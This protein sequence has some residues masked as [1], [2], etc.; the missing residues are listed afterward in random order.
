M[1]TQ[2]SDGSP[3]KNIDHDPFS[4]RSEDMYQA[5]RESKVPWY[6][7][8]ATEKP[9]M[10]PVIGLIKGNQNFQEIGDPDSDE[11]TKLNEDISIPDEP[12]LPT[13]SHAFGHSDEEEKIVTESNKKHSNKSISMLSKTERSSDEISVYGEEREDNMKKMLAELIHKTSTNNSRRFSEITT[14]SSDVSDQAISK[15]DK[16]DQILF[17]AYGWDSDSKIYKTIKKFWDALKKRVKNNKTKI[18]VVGEIID[19]ERKYASWLEWLIRWKNELKTNNIIKEKE[20][21]HLFGGV[22]ENIKIISDKFLEDIV[23]VYSEWE[24]TSTIG[25]IFVGIA[26]FFKIYVDYCNNNENAGKTLTELVKKNKKFKEYMLKQEKEAGDRF[27][28]FLITPIQRI[29]RYEMLVCSALKYTNKDYPDYAKLKKAKEM[30]HEVCMSN[31]KSM[32]DFIG[33]KRKLE[34][35]ELFG[36]DINLLLPQRNFIQEFSGMYMVSVNSNLKK[37]CRLILFSDCIM[38]LIDMKNIN[39]IVYFGNTVFDEH[40]FIYAKSDLKYYKNLIKIV[41]STKWF[42]LGADSRAIRDQVIKTCSEFIF[43]QKSKIKKKKSLRKQQDMFQNSIDIEIVWAEKQGEKLV[44]VIEATDSI[45]QNMSNENGIKNGSVLFRVFKRYNKVEDF[46]ITMCSEFSGKY[47]PPIP[48]KSVMSSDKTE[49]T[50]RRQINFELFFQTVM[51]HRPYMSHKSTIEFFKLNYVYGS[52]NKTNEVK[53]Y[54]L[55]LNQEKEFKSLKIGY[56]SSWKH[57]LNELNLEWDVRDIESFRICFVSEKYGEK[58]L[59]LYE[60]PLQVIENH[61][62]S[63]ESL[64]KKFIGKRVTKKPRKNIIEYFKEKNYMLYVRRVMFGP[65]DFSLNF[66]IPIKEL[67]LRY[68]QV[69]FDIKVQNINLPS[70]DEYLDFCGLRTFITCGNRKSWNNAILPYSELKSIIPSKVYAKKK[71]QVWENDILDSWQHYSETIL[72]QP[73]GVK[74]FIIKATTQKYYGWNLFWVEKYKKEHSW[75]ESNMWLIVKHNK[76]IIASE[77]LKN[78]LRTYDIVKTEWDH[79]PNAIIL[80]STSDSPVRLTTASVYPIYHLISYYKKLAQIGEEE[81]PN[82]EDMMNSA[83]NSQLETEEEEKKE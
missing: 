35:H 56:E 34:L 36:A 7:N 59:D 63:K 69:V 75:W 19:T 48:P 58:I 9:V 25:N 50:E 60:C 14:G 49:V 15:K 41:G 68:Y 18:R 6:M 78:Q 66:R 28:S 47:L 16:L 2:D 62:D 40:S 11:N 43:K 26:Q 39:R 82:F 20:V 27:E 70:A 22:I 72:D 77:D 13:N 74:T 53:I 65:D 76:I 5:R 73:E 81:S 64:F 52:E 57:I 83:E 45:T 33:Q 79:Y 44:Y 17:D 24:K 32:A 51:L 3:E 80:D 61:L 23:K 30:V 31:N 29:P 1:A 12:S 67:R 38:I 54:Y 42:I 21:D 37:E 8:S 46:H 10:L 4:E 55:E 71:K